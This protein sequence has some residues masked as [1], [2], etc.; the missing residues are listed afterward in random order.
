METYPKY[1]VEVDKSQ[2]YNLI[3]QL[4][5]SDKIEILNNLQQSTFV[6]RFEALLDSLRTDDL[7]YEEITK[8]VEEVRQERYE[9]GKHNA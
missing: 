4:N 6:K 1:N 5:P 3:N 8:E 9:N 2:I 7:T